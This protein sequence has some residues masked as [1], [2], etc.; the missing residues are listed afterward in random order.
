MI[1]QNSFIVLLYNFLACGVWLKNDIFK[2]LYI[3]IVHGCHVISLKG[4]K[5][6]TKIEVFIVILVICTIIKFI[7]LILY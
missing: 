4:F 7:Q 6:Q 5:K 1:A 2:S 3:Y